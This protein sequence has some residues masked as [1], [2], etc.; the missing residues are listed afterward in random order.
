MQ[1]CRL[2]LR[3]GDDDTGIGAG[4]HGFGKFAF[5]QVRL[6]GKS[7][8]HDRVQLQLGRVGDDGHDVVERDLA[9]AVGIERKLAKF[10]ARG[11]AVA[12][13]Q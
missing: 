4:D 7:A 5:D 10:V 6:A 12:A 9:L 3:G 8:V 11:L 13:E 2:A 1:P